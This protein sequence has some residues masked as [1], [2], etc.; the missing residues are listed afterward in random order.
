MKIEIYML[1]YYIQT[2]DEVRPQLNL[3]G[4]QIMFEKIRKLKD[5]KGFTLVRVDRGSGHPGHPGCPADPRL[6]W[7][8]R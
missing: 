3:G 6:D 1:Q 7:L 8:H 4:V 5:R 2:G